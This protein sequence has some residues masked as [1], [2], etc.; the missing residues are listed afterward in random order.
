[1]SQLKEDL[2]ASI[3]GK[4]KRNFGKDLSQVTKRELYDAAASSIMESIQSNLFATR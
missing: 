4:L 3:L 2:R 1:M